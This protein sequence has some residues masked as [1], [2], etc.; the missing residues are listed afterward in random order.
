MGSVRYVIKQ[1][2]SKVAN[3]DFEIELIKTKKFLCFLLFCKPT[4]ACCISGTNQPIF[5]G[6]S[7]KCSI[8]N[9]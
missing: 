3:T 7:A 5:M 6:F 1:N 9:V 4:T 8:K 2:E